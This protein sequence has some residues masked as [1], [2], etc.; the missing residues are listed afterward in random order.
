MRSMLPAES[1]VG[2]AA[3][4]LAGDMAWKD[5]VPTEDC[6]LLALRPG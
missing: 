6:A 1:E 5:S 3:M 2:I 4:C